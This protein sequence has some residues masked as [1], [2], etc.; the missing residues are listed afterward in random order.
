MQVPNKDRVGT[1]R[2]PLPSKNSSPCTGITVYKTASSK[3]L[4]MTRAVYLEFATFI[5]TVTP[6]NVFYYFYFTDEKSEA[7]RGTRNA[8]NYSTSKQ[9][10]QNLTFTW[11]NSKPVA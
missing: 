4:H 3:V 2:R 5:I 10:T 8:L 7:K 1:V 11:F 6:C 9:Q